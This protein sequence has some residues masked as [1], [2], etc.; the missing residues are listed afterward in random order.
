MVCRIKIWVKR[1]LSNIT[2]DNEILLKSKN[3]QTEE[4]QHGIY[5]QNIKYFYTNIYGYHRYA[6]AILTTIFKSEKII[7]V[8]I[9]TTY[10]VY[11]MQNSSFF[12]YNTDNYY[13][14]VSSKKQTR[15]ELHHRY[16]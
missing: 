1:K 5:K 16:R 11:I 10:L 4:G 7:N 8:S 13:N 3:Q 6:R 9:T 14:F 2:K 15:R 12:P